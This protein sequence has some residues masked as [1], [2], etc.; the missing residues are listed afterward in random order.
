MK[1]LENKGIDPQRITTGIALLVGITIIGFIDNSS[2]DFDVYNIVSADTSV[3]CFENK[4]CSPLIA[5]R[6]RVKNHNGIKTIP[7][8]APLPDAR[9]VNGRQKP[10]DPFPEQCTGR[11]PEQSAT[12]RQQWLVP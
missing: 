7:K 1:W 8:T 10:T 5:S 2:L 11:V 12:C 6:Y 3:Y 4:Q 9:G